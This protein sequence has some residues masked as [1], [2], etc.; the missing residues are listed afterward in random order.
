MVEYDYRKTKPVVS[1]MTRGEIDYH[2]SKPW[3]PELGL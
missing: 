3:L 2:L 1:A